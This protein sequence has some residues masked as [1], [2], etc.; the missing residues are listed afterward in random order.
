MKI[1]GKAKQGLKNARWYSLFD[2]LIDNA[3]AT[4]RYLD[5]H[6]NLE[7]SRLSDC[8]SFVY[9]LST[10][11]RNWFVKNSS[12]KC[13]F[14]DLFVRTWD[15]QQH[16]KSQQVIVCYVVSAFIRHNHGSRIFMALTDWYTQISRSEKIYVDRFSQK[17]EMYFCRCSSSF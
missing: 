13:I 15:K 6:T 9:I 12:F 4:G 10:L 5:K 17:L 8:I 7:S 2:P 1:Y 3:R 11:Q 16:V 14:V